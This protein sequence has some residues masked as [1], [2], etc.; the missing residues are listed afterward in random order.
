MIVIV[1]IIEFSLN[2][3][4][5]GY[6]MFSFKGVFCVM[7]QLLYEKSYNFMVKGQVVIIIIGLIGQLF[8]IIIVM[9]I[10]LGCKLYLNACA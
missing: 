7:L 8:I 10:H 1:G 9:M 2:E 5:L 4:T 6:Q 3:D